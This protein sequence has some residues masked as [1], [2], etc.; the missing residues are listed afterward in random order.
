MET[1]IFCKIVSG[2]LSCNRIYEDEKYLSFLDIFPR[3]AGHALVIPKK[4]YRWVY[5]VPDFE[6]YWGVAK[7]VANKIQKSLDSEYISFLTIGNE[8]LHA[9]IHILPQSSAKLKGIRF[10]EVVIFKDFEMKEIL[11]KINEKNETKK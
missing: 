2:N 11:N 8:V 6:E 10:E 1:C 9:H 4:H 7:K 5:D 3:V